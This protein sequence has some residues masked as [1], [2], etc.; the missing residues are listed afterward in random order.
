LLEAVTEG[1]EISCVDDEAETLAVERIR[2]GAAQRTRDGA[3]AL[4]EL[5]FARV[6]SGDS[7]GPER[8]VPSSTC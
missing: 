7:M 2:S 5:G 1:P 4:A 3:M 8:G 6:L